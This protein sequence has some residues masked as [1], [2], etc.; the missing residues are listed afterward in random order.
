M[1]ICKK[2]GEKKPLEQFE[3]TNAERGWRRH[4]CKSCTAKRVKQWAE[5][6]KKRIREYRREYH[7]EH[8]DEIIAKVNAWVKANPVAR[9]KNALAHYYRLQHEAILAYGGYRCV[10]CGEAEPLFLTIDHANGDGAAHRKQIGSLGGARFYRWLRDA[11][12]PAGFQV[13]CSNCNHGRFRNGGICP[14]KKA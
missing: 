13:L 14:H 11:G 3:I 5:R 12:Y 1:R 4:E 9:R 8:R 10:C 6:S 2:C 7:A